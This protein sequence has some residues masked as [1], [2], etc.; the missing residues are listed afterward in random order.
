LI[1]GKLL[2]ALDIEY[3]D[4]KL[5]SGFH[6]T[7]D[8]QQVRDIFFSQISR[9]DKIQVNSVVVRKN[10]TNP[11]LREPKKFYARF[12]SSLL[13]YVFQAYS[14]SDLCILINGCAIT[15]N[16]KVF[17][18]TVA[19]EIKNKMTNCKFRIFF[20]ESSTFYHL[21]IVDYISWAIYRKWENNDCQSYD[22]IKDK[23]RKP[24]LDIFWNGD[25]D[26]Y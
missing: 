1:S 22:L 13:S 23:L 6:A 5:C 19:D 18:Q 2:S 12:L 26:Y 16:K 7:E 25:K 20:P 15:A 4:K 3:L 24:E 8:K 9:M 17:K 21:Q 10:R 11:V 14:F